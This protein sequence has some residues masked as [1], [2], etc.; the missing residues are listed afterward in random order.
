MK[1][2]SP[3]AGRVDLWTTVLHEL[4]HVLGH[5]HDD[6]GYHEVG[7]QALAQMLTQPLAGVRRHQADCDE[8]RDQRAE[9]AHREKWGGNAQD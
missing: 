1:N 5:D 9:D 8:D 4:G 2:G 3:A 6:D 7:E